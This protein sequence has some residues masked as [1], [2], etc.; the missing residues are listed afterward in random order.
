MY[1]PCM[2]YSSRTLNF[3][4]FRYRVIFHRGV[5]YVVSI[6]PLEFSLQKICAVAIQVEKSSSSYGDPIDEGD[7]YS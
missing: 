5:H 4:H 6:F 1:P 3:L 2:K 7:M